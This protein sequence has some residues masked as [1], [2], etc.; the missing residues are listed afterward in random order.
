MTLSELLPKLCDATLRGEHYACK[1]G[2]FRL[3]YNSGN[4]AVARMCLDKRYIIFKF[5]DL[6]YLMNMLNFVQVLVSKYTEA[7]DDIN[8][9]AVSACGYTEFVQPNPL[10][11]SDIQYDGLFEKIKMPLL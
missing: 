3:L 9:Y 4:Q 7:R 1:N 6:C 5:A 8:S 10:C 11:T 2:V